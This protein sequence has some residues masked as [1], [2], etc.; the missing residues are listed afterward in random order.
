MKYFLVL[1][2][3]TLTS[4]SCSK[5]DNQ[6]AEKKEQYRNAV[7]EL[8]HGLKSELGKAMKSG[9]PTAALTVCNTKAPII[10]AEVSK[11][12]NIEVSRT[13]LK[14][15]NS[16]N[17][18]DEWETKV[19]QQFEQRL[20]QGEDPQTIE[21]IEHVKQGDK[22]QWRYMKAIPTAPVCLQCHGENIAPEIATTIKSLYPDDKATGF[23]V[24]DLRG[25]FTIKE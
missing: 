16:N 4:L 15:R 8:H 11:K 1:S 2:L 14:P 10:T 25:A 19:L 5:A 22:D 17:A 6:E 7:K 3:I 18:P 23:K 9:G 21:Y 20:A 12:L 13:S 24:G